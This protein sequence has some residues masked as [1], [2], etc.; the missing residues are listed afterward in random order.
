MFYFGQKILVFF[1]PLKPQLLY[2]PPGSKLED[3]C[4]NCTMY[5]CF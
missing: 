3:L 1:T 2:M 4:S 5:L